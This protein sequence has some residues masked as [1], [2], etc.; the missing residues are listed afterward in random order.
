M[1]FFIARATHARLSVHFLTGGRP[2]KSSILHYSTRGHIHVFQG[3][4]YLQNQLLLFTSITCTTHWAKDEAWNTARG[5]QQT[6]GTKEILTDCGCL[7]LQSRARGRSTW[8]IHCNGH[9]QQSL[10]MVAFTWDQVKLICSCKL[11][12]LLIRG[13]SITNR[14][15][16]R[17]LIKARRQVG[18]QCY[19]GCTS[20][21]RALQQQPSYCWP[22]ITHTNPQVATLP[23]SCPRALK[24][25]AQVPKPNLYFSLRLRIRKLG[26]KFS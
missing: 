20:H 18:M 21:S 17:C 4:R 9:S 22:I 16:L 5:A 13:N 15:K 8:W 11:N 7:L 3:N 24:F 12:I 25:T 10:G 2:L 23:Y 6:S 14:K 26:H 19:F 1:H